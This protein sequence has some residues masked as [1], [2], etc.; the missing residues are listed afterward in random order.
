MGGGGW[1]YCLAVGGKS[2]QDLHCMPFSQQVYTSHVMH[3]ITRAHL[4]N[5]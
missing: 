3:R 1:E 4:F 2:D 5:A